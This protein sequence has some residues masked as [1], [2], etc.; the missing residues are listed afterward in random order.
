V[1]T[2]PGTSAQREVA[3]AE[4]AY[5]DRKKILYPGADTLVLHDVRHADATAYHEVDL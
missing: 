5:L 2:A 1:I 3:K 4:A